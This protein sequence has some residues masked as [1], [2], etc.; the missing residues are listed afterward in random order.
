MHI[1]MSK[2]N[3]FIIFLSCQLGGASCAT[4]QPLQKD[5]V[6]FRVA[7][8]LFKGTADRLTPTEQCFQL[9]DVRLLFFD[10]QLQLS[11]GG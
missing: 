8:F 10:N 4:Q 9:L 7:P 2:P 11:H 5:G 1:V 3:F 6:T